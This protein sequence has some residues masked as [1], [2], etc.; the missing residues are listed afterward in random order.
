MLSRKSTKA[1]VGGAVAALAFAIPV[2]DDGV[3]MSEGLGIVSAFV[4]GFQTVYWVRN[5]EHDAQ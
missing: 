1:F 3:V 2:V 4:V 5:R